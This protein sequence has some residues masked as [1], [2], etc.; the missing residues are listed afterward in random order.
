LN[1]FVIP[2]HFNFFITRKPSPITGLERNRGFGYIRQQEG[3]MVLTRLGIQKEKALRS[4]NAGL[5]SILYIKC[6]HRP[7]CENANILHDFD[8]Y[9]NGLVEYNY[10]QYKAGG[11]EVKRDELSQFFKNSGSGGG[12][13]PTPPAE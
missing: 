2:S 13:T 12:E 6:G 7:F 5:F 9:H 1:W 8:N 11:Y 4:A 10:T 3:F